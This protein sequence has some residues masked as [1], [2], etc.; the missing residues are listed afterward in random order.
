VVTSTIIGHLANALAVG[1]IIDLNQFVTPSEQREI[2]A[3]FEQKGMAAL[4]PVFEALG[5]RYDYG[6]L[7]LVRAALQGS[8]RNAAKGNAHVR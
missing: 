2:A 7:K 5:G 3:V 6:R 1:E 4:A 8:D